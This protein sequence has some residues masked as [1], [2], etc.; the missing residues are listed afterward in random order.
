MKTFKLRASAGGDL[1]SASGKLIDGNK[2]YLQEWVKSQIYGVQKQI[3]SK[4]LEKGSVM[5]AEAI[6]K[7]IQWAGLDF[8]LKNEQHYED[9]Y[10]TGTPDIIGSDYV[11]DTKCSWDC[12]TF[13]LFDTEIPTKDYYFQ[14]QIYMHLTGKKKAKLIYMLLNTPEYLTWEVPADY[15]AIDPKFRHKVF[16]IEYSPEVIADLQ[17]RVIAAREYINNLIQE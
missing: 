10:F 13:P 3:K 17:Q 4:Y 5:E 1:W 12:F 7:A 2:K 6:D 8:V 9:D 16:E 14:L 15:D 11:V